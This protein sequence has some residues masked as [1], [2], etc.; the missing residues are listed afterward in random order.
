MDVRNERTIRQADHDRNQ[1]SAGCGRRG[2]PLIL[3]DGRELLDGYS[4][5]EMSFSGRGQV[6]IP[7]PN[8]LQDWSYEFNGRRYQLPLNEPEPS[9]SLIS[10]P[11][12]W[13]L[14][15]AVLAKV[16]VEVVH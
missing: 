5:D 9:T 11:K 2:S 16:K 15:S 10:R 12:G 7:W 14:P 3:V 1:R 6:L 13:E 8:R 4:A